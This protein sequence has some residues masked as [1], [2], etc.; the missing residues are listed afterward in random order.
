MAMCAGVWTDLRL[1][2]RENIVAQYV[3]LVLLPVVEMT[4]NV[5]KDGHCEPDSDPAD[6][7]WDG[8]RRVPRN[9]SDA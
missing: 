5:R 4:V 2:S 3:L 8:L 7:G 1:W 9:A 6:E